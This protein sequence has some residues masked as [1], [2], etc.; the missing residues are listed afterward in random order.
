MYVSDTY[1]RRVVIYTP[2]VLSIPLGGQG[3]VN[4]ASL[5][6]YAIGTVAVSGAIN[7]KDT[8]TITIDGTGYTYTVVST[9]T[10]ETITD[11]LVKL[12]NKGPDPNVIATPDDTTDNVILTARKPGS[13]GTNITIAANTSVNAQVSATT[14]SSTLNLYLENPSSIAPGTLIEVNGQNICDNTAAGDFT[15]P[16]LPVVL[17]G[18][19][20]F[21]DGDRVPLLYV[22]PTQINAQMPWE[23]TDRTSV[24]VYARNTHADGSIS[25]TSPIAV[26]I[27]P[28]N[29]GIFAQ[30]G[31]DP[32]PGF[33]YH[34]SS[35]AVSTIQIDGTIQAGD[36]ANITVA[37]PVYSNTY[38]YTVLSTDTL[39]SVTNALVNLINAGPDPNVTAT[40][41]NQ[42]ESIL[43]TANVPGPAGEGITISQSVTGTNA[44][45]SVNVYNATTCCDNTQGA[46]VTN[47][48]PAIPAR[49]STF[50][51]QVWDRRRHPLSIPE[52]YPLPAI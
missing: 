21:I 13:S 18:C 49:L 17:G 3:L 45:L 52:R 29:P 22:S 16:F 50:W 15:Q 10:L 7:A 11:A 4:A 39:Y 28:E 32:R 25:V 9:D 46:L 42:F 43:L 40:A 6:I 27:V 30:Y 8:V 14:A 23:F 20:L 1:N 34:G 44:E 24:S 36:V 26:T 48:N 38:S 19:E 51:R 41:A 35:S 12:I 5:N 47:D 37:G 33:V 2:G 31:T